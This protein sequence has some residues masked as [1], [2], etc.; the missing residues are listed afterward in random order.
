MEFF[1]RGDDPDDRVDSRVCDVLAVATGQFTQKWFAR[2][3]R[4]VEWLLDDSRMGHELAVLAKVRRSGSRRR[5]RNR[6]IGA[7]LR[8]PHHQRRELWMHG[9]LDLGDHHRGN[10]IE[11]AGTAD[12][13]RHVLQHGERIVAFAE[14]PPIDRFQPAPAVGKHDE[15]RKDHCQILGPASSEHIVHGLVAL[16]QQIENQENREN[17]HHGEHRPARQCVLKPF[18]D[19]EADL[20]QPVSKDCVGNG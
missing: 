4:R 2:V 11:A 5:G 18:P 9:R 7:G 14:E 12:L 16:K 8:I 1:V 20:E 13:L 17:R 19:D 6:P 3:L 15:G 10:A